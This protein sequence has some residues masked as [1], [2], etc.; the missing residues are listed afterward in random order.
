[1]AAILDSRLGGFAVADPAPGHVTSL[2]RQWKGGDD[3]ALDR[4][5]PLVY[6]EL[7][8]IAA[9]HLRR[10]RAGHS[11]QPTGLV[12]EADLRLVAAPG[13]DLQDRAHFFGVSARLM[14]QILVDH[15]RARGAAKRGGAAR[16]VTLT[17]HVEPA[18]E[19][20]LDLL[21]LDEALRRLEE[22]DPVQGRVVELRYF[23]GLSIE[24][25][26]EVLGKSPATVNREWRLARAWLRR[27][28]DT[29]GR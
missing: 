9:R 12:H 17:D 10:E 2:L 4:L 24:E 14:R 19:R 26:A 20:D 23:T 16:R 5:L 6:A 28:L 15:A 7:R 8:R 22:M 27:E 29:P 11:L 25:T 21:A 18:V 13:P 1:M 3:S